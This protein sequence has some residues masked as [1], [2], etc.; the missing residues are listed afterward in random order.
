VVLGEF[1]W[2]GGGAPQH[3]PYLS[4]EQQAHWISEEIEATRALADGWLSWPF[5]DTPSSRDIS[6]YAGLVKPDL[7][8]KAWGRKFKELA[9]TLPELKKPTPELPASIFTEALT[10]NE[11]AL[12]QIHQD[13]TKAIEQTIGKP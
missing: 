5:A 11:D 4:Q 10:A 3:H 1:G 2:Y 9:A 13:Y 7:T 8:P 12:K 6:L